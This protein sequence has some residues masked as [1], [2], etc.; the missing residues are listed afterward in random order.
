MELFG[1]FVIFYMSIHG[2]IVELLLLICVCYDNE[3]S[4]ID[5]ERFM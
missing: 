1:V 3:R 4:L 2:I 5:S